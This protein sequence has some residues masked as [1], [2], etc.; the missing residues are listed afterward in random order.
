MYMEQVK[1]I[2]NNFRL[3]GEKGILDLYD[4]LKDDVVVVIDQS[5]LQT[6]KFG[7]FDFIYIILLPTIVLAAI[8]AVYSNIKDRKSSKF[9]FIFALLISLYV[10]LLSHFPAHHRPIRKLLK[11]TPEFLKIFLLSLS[12]SFSIEQVLVDNPEQ[13]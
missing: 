8:Y 2:G 3:A 1:K 5:S 13:D 12:P 4:T 7:F 11:R 9:F 10:F 6:E